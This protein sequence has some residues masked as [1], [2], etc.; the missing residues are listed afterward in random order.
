MERRTPRFQISC[1]KVGLTVL[2]VFTVEKNLHSNRMYKC[3]KCLCSLK[4]RVKFCRKLYFFYYSLFRKVFSKR[5]L[6]RSM[7]KTLW[8]LL[9]RNPYLRFTANIQCT[10]KLIQ[11]WKSCF[12]VLKWHI[13]LM[14]I[15]FVWNIV[16]SR[17]VKNKSIIEADRFNSILANICWSKQM[18]GVFKP[19]FIHFTIICHKF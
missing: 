10:C 13:R 4:E 6:F 7:L 2:Y 19:S 11:I 14:D 8:L 16:L 9:G 5:C 3:E 12:K 1:L 15:W 18:I 17:I